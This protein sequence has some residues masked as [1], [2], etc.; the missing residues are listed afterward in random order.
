MSNLTNSTIKRCLVWEVK[1]NRVVKTQMNSYMAVIWGTILLAVIV[2]EFIVIYATT[3]IQNLRRSPLYWMVISTFVNQALFGVTIC[4]GEMT[5]CLGGPVG[6]ISLKILHFFESLGKQSTVIGLTSLTL[7]QYLSVMSKSNNKMT[8]IDRYGKEFNIAIHLLYIW[9]ISTLLSFIPVFIEHKVAIT[10]PCLVSAVVL[11]FYIML[12]CKLY[13]A[14]NTRVGLPHVQSSDVRLVRSLRF[15][16]GSGLLL[17]LTWI[18]ACTARLSLFVRNATVQED[19]KGI[20]V[21]L[22]F[23]I[24]YPLCQPLLYIFVTREVRMYLS[25]L[26]GSYD[27]NCTIINW[28]RAANIQPGPPLS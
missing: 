19:S 2:L 1:N 10:V 8:T 14:I 18:P 7:L 3:K 6:C 16:K 15:I 26:L 24:I 5:L 23:S 17:L 22:H 21:L 27:I 11:V 25:D 12:L 28:H 20:S 13:V 9:G 4:I